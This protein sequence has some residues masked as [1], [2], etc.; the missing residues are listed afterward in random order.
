MYY[1]IILLICMLE[2][3]EI[4]MLEVEDNIILLSYHFVC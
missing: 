4:C 3:Q 1:L 2:V